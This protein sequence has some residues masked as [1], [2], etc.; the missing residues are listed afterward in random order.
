MAYKGASKLYRSMCPPV[1]HG[2]LAEAEG[3]RSWADKA[4]DDPGWR[5]CHICGRQKDLVFDF[6]KL[7]TL[8]DGEKVVKECY[9]HG[10]KEIVDCQT[11]ETLV[12][13]EPPQW[14]CVQRLVESV[15][16]RSAIVVRFCWFFL[17]WMF[18]RLVMSNDVTF[19][20]VARIYRRRNCG[21]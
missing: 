8:L 15:V 11:G 1:V 6:V 19:A 7:V 12:I 21:S 13:P 3:W 20:L 17:A 9:W 10:P 5:C 16:L 2:A 14:P 4:V 18:W